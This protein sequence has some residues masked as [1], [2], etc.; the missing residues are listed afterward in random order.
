MNQ[1][2]LEAVKQEMAK[3]N[4]SILGVRELKWPGMGE[5]NS[6]DFYAN[7]FQLLFCSSFTVSHGQQLILVFFLTEIF[8]IFK[9]YHHFQLYHLD[10]AKL[11]LS[12]HT[13]QILIDHHHG[14][15]QSSYSLVIFTYIASLISL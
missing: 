12:I 10:Q 15:P 8:P 3:V 1:G 14:T 7:V 13:F 6:D 5:F 2:K 4:I 11:F 9:I